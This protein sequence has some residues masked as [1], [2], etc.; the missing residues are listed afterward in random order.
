[1]GIIKELVD[2]N[3]AV[4]NDTQMAVL[5]IIKTASSP[6]MAFANTNVTENLVFA[7]NAL[8]KMGLI[9]V[10]NNL[11]ILTD[12]GE[13]MLQYHD[14]VDE[15]GMVNDEGNA[16]LD[17]VQSTSDSFKN[18]EVKEEFNLIKTLL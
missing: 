18:Q 15:T 1:M 2:A 9:K 10:G 8:A 14:L 16:V 3:T 13:N 7:R 17:R 11:S 6:Q 12:E 5:I 4:L